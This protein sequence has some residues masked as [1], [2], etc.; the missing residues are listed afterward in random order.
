MDAMMG[1]D[2]LRH[3]WVIESAEDSTSKGR[4]KFC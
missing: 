3:Y 1:G 2:R 4:C